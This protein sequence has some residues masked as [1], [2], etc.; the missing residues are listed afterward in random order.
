[1]FER[2]RKDQDFQAEVEAHIQLEAERLRQQGMPEM[3]AA[4]AARRAFGNV[5]RAHERFYEAGRWLWWEHLRQD[6]RYAARMLAKNP[7]FAATAIL[8]LGLGIGANTAIFSLIDA[9]ML[10]F[11]P[12][13]H[14]DE[15]MQIERVVPKRSEPSPVYTNAIWEQVR[16]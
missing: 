9:V 15:L 11:L 8:T 14:P 4:A 12:I 5:V 7:G 2:K 3:E 1:M 16:D 6:L 10:R 13:L